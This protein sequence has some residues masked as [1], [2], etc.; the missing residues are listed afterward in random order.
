MSA[1]L[2]TVMLRLLSPVNPWQS[3]GWDYLLSLLRV[4]IQSLVG[5][6]RFH[7]PHSATKKKKRLIRIS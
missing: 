2:L 7:K 6:L 4:Q 3:S 5:E 1:S